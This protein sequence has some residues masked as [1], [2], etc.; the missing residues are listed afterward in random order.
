VAVAAATG[1]AAAGFAAGCAAGFSAGFVAAGALVG[2]A[3]AAVGAAGVLPPQA[4]I[5]IATTIRTAT[6]NVG[7]AGLLC[8][9]RAARGTVRCY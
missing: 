7:T 1:D 4:I 3:G 9:N 5:S 8:R 6:L 2:G